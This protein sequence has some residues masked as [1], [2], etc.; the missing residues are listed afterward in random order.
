MPNKTLSSFMIWAPKYRENLPL[1]NS[2]TAIPKGKCRKL[3]SSPA[4]AAA[5]GLP[6]TAKKPI[7][8]NSAVPASTNTDRQS[9]IQSAKP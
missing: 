2:L 7:K 4:I 6:P 3:T 9:G 1:I 5:I 8:I